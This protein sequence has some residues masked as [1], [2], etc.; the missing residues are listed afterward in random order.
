MWLSPTT[1]TL[2]T[3]LVLVL[4]G[5]AFVGGLLVGRSVGG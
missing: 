2:L 1:I 5:L 4:L 3:L